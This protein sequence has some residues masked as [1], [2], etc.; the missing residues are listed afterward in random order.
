MNYLKR[1]TRKNGEEGVSPVIGVM[2][3][4]IVTIIIAATVSAFAGNAISGTQKAPSANVELHVKNGGD[5]SHSYFT[6]KVLGVSEPIPTKNLKVVTSW[7][8][9]DRTTR[10]ATTGGNTTYAG[11]ASARIL[12]DTTYNPFSVPTGY[13]AGVNGWATNTSHVYDAQWGNFTWTAGTACFDNPSSDYSS[14]AYSGHTGA[15]PMQ[16]ILGKG[17]NNLNQGDIVTVRIIHIPSG[18]EILDQQVAVE[19]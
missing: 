7:T 18:K 14:N 9:T 19:A 1:K 4:L 15:D 2:L 11:L 8:A 6:M 3:M 5:A 17:W 16:A 12:E 13:G 10:N